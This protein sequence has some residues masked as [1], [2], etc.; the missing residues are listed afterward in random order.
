[1]IKEIFDENRVNSLFRR[2]WARDFCVKSNGTKSRGN[3]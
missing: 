3:F 2:I 1:M